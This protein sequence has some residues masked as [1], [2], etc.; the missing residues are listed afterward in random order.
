MTRRKILSLGLLLIIA[1][2]GLASTAK[3]TRAAGAQLYLTPS[4]GTFVIGNTFKVGIRVNSGGA[5][6]NSA[7]GSLSYDKDLIEA[8]SVAK[9][10][11]FMFWT[12]EPSASGGSIRFGGGSPT[13]YTGTAG[14][15]ITV[16]FKAKKAG[17]AQVRFTSGAVLANDGKGSNILASMGSGS[18]TIAP[19]VEAPKTEPTVAKP[20][21][22]DTA[23]KTNKEPE[24][25]KPPVESEYNKPKIS[26]ASHPDQS[27][28]YLSGDVKFSWELPKSV[29]GVSMSF[30]KNP[31]SD[32]GTVSDGLISEKEFVG[33][34]S[35]VWYLH[36]RF[37]DAN[38]WG[39]T[40]HYKV[41]IDKNPPDSFVVNVGSE[42]GKWP[43][44]SFETKDKESGMD[45]YQVFVGSLEHQAHELPAEK[46]GVELIGL[47]PG[48]HTVLLK[49]YDKAG[50]QRVETAEFII[51]P[52]GAPVIS[53]YP[54]E[55][56]PSDRFYAKGTAPASGTV[57]IF[58]EKDGN[59]ISSSSVAVDAEGKWLY[60]YP[61]KLEE[62]RYGAYA[63]ARNPLGMRSEPSQKISFLVSP[64]VFASVG[65]FIIDY[66]TVIVSLIFMIVLIILL[67]VFLFFFIRKRLKKETIEVEEVLHRNLSAYRKDMDE[68]FKRIIE[69]DTRIS[70][71]KEK[72][73]ARERL[74]QGLDR[75]EEK[76]LKEVKDVEDILK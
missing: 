11:I 21:T 69:K 33:T 56:K 59:I 18:Y 55:V 35:G 50:N 20:K 13:S 36:L 57:V 5:A 49:A 38:K 64:P 62:G 4:T 66:F 45:K 3:P 44:I 41:M 19:K 10:S 70:G 22:T 48:K 46:T 17:T 52:I 27:K 6:I 68:E 14:G 43:V 37:K 74:R 23:T 72:A 30:D 40:G 12:T 9:G 8:V 2:S 32:P 54:A 61:E 25:E 29:V 60:L 39:T 76:I 65:A 67:V 73:E 28:W 1:F 26:S 24:V 58:I 47:E 75:A 71:R 51:E 42:A 7:E 34:E 15:V 63:E 31:T 16:T 53:D